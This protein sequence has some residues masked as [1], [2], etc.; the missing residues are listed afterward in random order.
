MADPP[1]KNPL[2]PRPP[3]PPRLDTELTAAGE[4][5]DDGDPI[6]TGW[7][8][9][10]AAGWRLAGRSGALEFDASSLEN[11]DLSGARPSRLSL[12]DCRLSTCNLANLSAR[13][14]SIIRASLRR[15]RLTGLTWSEGILRDVLFEDCRADLASFGFSRLQRV[16]FVGCNLAEADFEGVRA[17]SVSFVDCDLRRAAF[18]QARFERSEMRGCEM[19]G[20]A[21]V[22]GLR[23]VGLPADDILGLAGTL[24]AALGIRTL[25]D[26]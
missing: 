9:V 20:I 21:G 1:H 16:R 22:E 24:A 13:R 17:E 15:S 26:G 4:P 12:I 25:E 10:L 14:P 8:G 11:A 18:S 2:A 5:A 23:G 6:E 3:V 19:G 7:S